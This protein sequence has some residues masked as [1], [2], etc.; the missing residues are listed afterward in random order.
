M[1]TLIVAFDG[2]DYDLIRRFDCD[3][4][5]QD[6]FGTI[7]NDTGIRKRE[8]IELFSA[9]ISGRTI[10]E[11]GI[12]RYGSSKI[13]ALYPPLTRLVPPPILRNN[14]RGMT[15]ITR[16]LKTLLRCRA[17]RAS[18]FATP[19]IFDHVP[20]SQDIGVPSY[21][22]H[23]TYW[24]RLM[25]AFTNEYGLD[26][27]LWD[28]EAEFLKR[29]QTLFQ[30]LQ[31]DYSLLMCHFHKPDVRQ[32]VFYDYVDDTA[33]IDTELRDVYAEMDALA[34]RIREEAAD[35]Y[36][37]ILFMSDHGLPTATE[38]NTNAFYSSTQPV[39][40][41]VPHITDFYAP[42]VERTPRQPADGI[43]V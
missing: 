39:P 4:L 15:A 14:I 21:S 30:E 38:H 36:D 27:F 12:R 13:S 22:T 32:H 3:N 6:K 11:T 19:T 5:I 29:K 42:I 17:Y 35:R 25:T 43:T 16:T 40:G 18:D 26:A 34:G 37:W 7:D 10:D 2:L 1:N 23:T 9:F 20:D 8:T 28:S 24:D 41:N 31:Q 33:D